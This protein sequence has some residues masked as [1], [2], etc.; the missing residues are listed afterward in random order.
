MRLSEQEIINAICMHLA[1][2]KQ[3]QPTQIEVE[4]MWD[5][6]YGFSAEVHSEGRSYIIIASTIKEAIARYMLTQ[7]NVEVI[8]EQIH[9]Q[10]NEEIVA[11]IIYN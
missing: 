5:E 4:M 10:L 8:S 1:E 7:H 6:D 11:D 3:L 2:R 9:L